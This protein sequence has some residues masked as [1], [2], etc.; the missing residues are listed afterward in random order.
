MKTKLLWATL[1]LALAAALAAYLLF[2]PPVANHPSPPVGQP[3][4]DVRPPPPG[5]A[6]AASE[7]LPEYGP[8][9]A[10]ELT[11]QNGQPFTLDFLKGRPWIA[12]F[13]FTSCAGTCPQMTER[14]AA[15]QRRLPGELHFVSIS[16]DP[17]RDTPPVLA[18]YASRYGADPVRW[19][20]LTG[21]AEEIPRL[22]SQGF[23]LSYA[24]GT[25]PAE[26]IVHSVRFVLVDPAGSIRGYY[27]STDPAQLDR[28]AADAG[29]ILGGSP[30]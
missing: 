12:D 7:G 17:Q 30:E 19:H 8:V 4:A 11:D 24:E 26:P 23:R 13:I 29:S 25:D 28:L 15:L 16:V 1:L 9:P 22:V 5:P 3:P 27:D 10:F 6:P 2:P 20:F 21:S 14:M 18:E